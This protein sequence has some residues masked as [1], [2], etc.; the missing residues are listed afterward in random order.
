MLELARN[1]EEQS[2]LRNAIREYMK[3][4]NSA[5]TPDLKQ[6]PQVKWVARE[7]MRL[8]PTAALGS[9]RVIPKEIAIKNP[10]DK[11]ETWIIP[12]GSFCNIISYVVLRNHHVFG[13][14]VDTFD[15]SRW[16]SPTEDMLKAYLPFAAGKRN[17]QGMALAYL[18][19]HYVIARLTQKYKFTIETEG[20]PHYL[21][22]LRPQGSKILVK[23][24]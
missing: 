17:C 12:K 6:C 15:P 23:P 18:E 20:N 4:C 7:A 24:L 16:E 11:S 2:S 19:L 8:H 1:P 21:V 22:T 3:N 14:T 5:E 10:Q 13:E 9:S